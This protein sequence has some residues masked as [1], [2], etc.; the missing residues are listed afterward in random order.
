MLP[1]GCRDDARSQHRSGTFADLQSQIVVRSNTNTPD[2]LARSAAVLV[3]R[4]DLCAQRW[5]SGRLIMNNPQMK[6]P[7]AMAGCVVV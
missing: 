6:R 1:E 7:G 5:V 4:S 3:A 2:A